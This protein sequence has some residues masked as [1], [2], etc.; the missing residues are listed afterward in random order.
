MQ[1]MNTQHVLLELHFYGN[2]FSTLFTG[3]YYKSWELWTI[4][5]IPIVYRRLCFC[6]TP[7]YCLSL[8]VR[9]QLGRATSNK[10]VCCYDKMSMS[11]CPKVNYSLVAS[12]MRQIDLAE[13]VPPVRLTTK[14][15]FVGWV[16]VL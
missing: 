3:I 6:V 13:I 11:N 15:I 7:F 4:I 8:V 16:E 2:I 1:S 14:C 12:V 10:W 5:C 9:P